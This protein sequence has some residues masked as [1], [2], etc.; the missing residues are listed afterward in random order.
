MGFESTSFEESTTEFSR[1]DE[2]NSP[3]DNQEVETTNQLGPLLYTH[4][5]P[6]FHP[7]REEEDEED[8]DINGISDNDEE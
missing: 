7:S 5:D 8:V 4:T 3:K 1:M 6:N 2:V